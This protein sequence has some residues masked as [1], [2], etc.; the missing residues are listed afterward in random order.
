MELVGTVHEFE[1]SSTGYVRIVG[2]EGEVGQQ[3]I[4]P[5]FSENWE[6]MVRDWS[7]ALEKVVGE[8][9]YVTYEEL[10]VCLNMETADG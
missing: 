6:L 8:A 2:E 7:P 4:K 1:Q 3:H 9:Y 10:G 5:S